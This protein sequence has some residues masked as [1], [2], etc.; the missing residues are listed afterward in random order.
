METSADFLA[1]ATSVDD[2]DGPKA[3][4]AAK[5]FLRA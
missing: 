1:I 3:N 2:G 4:F 5:S